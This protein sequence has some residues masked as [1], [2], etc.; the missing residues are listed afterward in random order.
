MFDTDKGKL[1]LDLISFLPNSFLTLVCHRPPL[2]PFSPINELASPK[3]RT[4]IMIAAG[5]V[6][7]IGTKRYESMKYT[8]IPESIEPGNKGR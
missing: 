4:D 3:T 8:D 5:I 6:R 7:V 2:I 1:V